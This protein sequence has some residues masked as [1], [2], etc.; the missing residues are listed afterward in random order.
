MRHEG[1]FLIAGTVLLAIG[2]S[3]VSPIGPYLV[4]G[5]MCLLVGLLLAA[6]RVDR[7]DE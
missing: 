5:A 7:F 1:A 3:Y 2:A 6:P 4:V